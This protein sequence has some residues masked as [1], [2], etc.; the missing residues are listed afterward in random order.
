MAWKVNE[1]MSQRQA[2]VESAQRPER[3]R[4]ALCRGYGISRPT[5][6]KWPAR[7][8]DRGAGMLK[9]ESRHPQSSPQQTDAA[10]EAR[11]LELREAHPTWGGRKLRAVL[12]QAEA[13]AALVVGRVGF[14]PTRVASADFKSAA[15]AIPP[16]TRRPSA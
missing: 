5:G 13:R 1:P 4:A 15:S 8:Q 2:F 3:N 12:Q 10:T 14:E 16:P 7:A 11:V 9:E 6:Y